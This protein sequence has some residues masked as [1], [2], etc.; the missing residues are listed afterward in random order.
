MFLFPASCAQWQSRRL[1]RAVSILGLFELSVGAAPRPEGA[2]ELAAAR[3]AVRHVNRRGLLPGYALRLLTNDTKVRHFD[4]RSG[5]SDRF[6]GRKHRTRAAGA[7][8]RSPARTS[9]RIRSAHDGECDPGVGVDRLF[10]ALYGA[11]RGARVLMLLGS[12]CSEVTE[13]IAKI[14]PY[15]NIVQMQKGAD[16]VAYRARATS[17]AAPR[18]RRAAHARRAADVEC[19]HAPRS[20]SVGRPHRFPSKRDESPPN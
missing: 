9:T 17:A 8:R 15:W 20:Q 13:T 16:A 6:S 2:S 5:G 12:A 3:L 19:G 18:T 14:V 11:G 4:H 10:H 7:A 1:S